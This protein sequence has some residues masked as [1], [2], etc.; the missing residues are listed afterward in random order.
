MSEAKDIRVRFRLG[1]YFRPGSHKV[2]MAK[3]ENAKLAISLP[4]LITETNS[5][6]TK[7]RPGCA[8]SLTGSNPK[9]LF[10]G[11]NVKC[12]L[13][14]SDP[15]GHDVK[16]HFDVA[17]VTDEATAKNLDVAVTCTC[18]AF[19]YWGG[20]WNTHQRD[21][22]EGEPR[23][24]L[25]AP[26]ER[27]DLRDGFVVCKHIKAVSERILPSVQHNIVKILR[28][29]HV[30]E[31]EAKK[32]VEA[33]APGLT[34]LERKQQEMRDRQD[35]L[36]SDK[37][38]NSEVRKKLEQGVKNRS[39]DD[40]VK[41][42]T[43]ATPEEKKRVPVLSPKD[44]PAPDA[45]EEHLQDIPEI[46]GLE[47]TSMPSPPPPAPVPDKKPTG[48]KPNTTMPRLTQ[49]DREQ[50]QRLMREEQQRQNRQVNERLRNNLKSR[51]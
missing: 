36:K 30:E 44:V 10:L 7:N 50:T 27:L 22:L 25:T 17:G 31:N 9:D 49:K 18:P 16:V 48:P 38:Q 24:L 3:G 34:R 21:A 51:R 37:R 32:K 6:S 2:V 29:R 1:D 13:K 35:K 23:D 20:Q 28:K 45:H 19:L 43:P 11:Y 41:R 4:T 33:P 47:D 46:E 15:N 8:P 40:V 26:T 39:L 14:S 12:S 42:D 5:F